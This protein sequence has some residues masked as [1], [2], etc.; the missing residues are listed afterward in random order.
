M[1]LLMRD[2]VASVTFLCTPHKGSEIATKLYALPKIVR[3]FIVF[4]LNFWYRIFGDKHPNVL[5]ACRQLTASKED[6]LDGIGAHDGIFM[7]S[8][9]TVLEKS[10]DDFIMGIPLYFSRR[11]EQDESDGLVSV[12]SSKFASYNGHCIEESVSHTEIVDFMVKKDKKEKIY[13][14]Y[15]T[16]CADLE[17]RGY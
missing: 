10:S 3:G 13:E 6:V 16:L 5:E 15:K 1:R 12:E 7:Q 14:F 17:Q 2:K 8:Y 11:Y 9:S 4:W